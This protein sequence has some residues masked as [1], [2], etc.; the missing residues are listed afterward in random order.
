MDIDS[1]FNIPSTQKEEV[2]RS[3]EPIFIPML[4]KAIE[5][6]YAKTVEP[7]KKA[8]FRASGIGGCGR[9]ILYKLKGYEDRK[10]AISL[11]ALEQG[12]FIHEFLQGALG[13]ILEASED[14]VMLFNN[15][16]SGHFDGEVLKDYL[17]EIKTMNHLA[18]QRMAVYKKIYPKYLMQAAVYMKARGKKKCIFVFVNKSGVVNDDFKKQYPEIHPVFLEIIVDYNDKL[19][20]SVRDKVDSLTEHF[21]NNTM[22]EYEK[23]LS[24][25]SYCPFKEQCK[26]DRK[27]EKKAKKDK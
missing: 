3:D 14:E 1:L 25:C 16:L 5:D 27:A 15:R 4:I 17:L 7:S 9:A 22:P 10:D 2:V 23:I 13:D 20:D 19:F 11:L 6:K 21:N 12:T 18:Y 26:K 24:E 8:V